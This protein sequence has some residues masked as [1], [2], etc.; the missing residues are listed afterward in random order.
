MTPILYRTAHGLLDLNRLAP[1]AFSAG[2]VSECLAKINRYNGRTPEPWSVASHS[3]LVAMLCRPQHRAQALLHDAHE[4]ILGYLVAPAVRLICSKSQPV[5][6]GIVANAIT[7]TKLDLDRQIFAAW[8][9]T[10]SPD[11]ARK[12]ATADHIALLAEGAVFFG[13]EAG[14][15]ISPETAA[16]V[17]RAV[18]LIRELPYGQNWRAARERWLTFVHDLA[19]VGQLRLPPEPSHPTR[20]ARAV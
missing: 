12:V 8:D 15:E 20:T 3:V 18:G 2:V 14:G 17:D 7:Q 1:T 19:S 16:E 11:G 5:A 9:V 13:A 6:G 10:W 4:A